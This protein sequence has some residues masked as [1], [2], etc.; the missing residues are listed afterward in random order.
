MTD[1]TLL[2]PMS[3]KMPAW[4]KRKLRIMAAMHEQ[5]LTTEI[6]VRLRRTLSEDEAR[7]AAGGDLGGTTP[8]AVTDQ[9]MSHQEGV[10]T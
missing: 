3:M 4:M 1:E 5:S 8:A 9:V 7:L 6:L 10:Q 2:Q